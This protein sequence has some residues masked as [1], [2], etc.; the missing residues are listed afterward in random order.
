MLVESMNGRCRLRNMPA[1]HALQEELVRIGLSVPS[2]FRVFYPRVRDREDI[3]VLRCEK[4]GVLL[5]S[6]I[7]HVNLGHY[8]EKVFNGL[9]AQDRA[10]ALRGTKED[11]V[12]R[13]RQFTSIIANKKWLDVGTGAG[14]VLN[15]LASVARDVVAVEPQRRSRESLE[16]AGYRVY[17]NLDE[18]PDQDFDVITLFHVFEHVVNPIEMLAAVKRRLAPGGLLVIEVPHADDILISLFANEAF[19]AHTFW[20]EH[21][22]LHTRE[23]LTAFLRA[24]GFSSVIIQG[25]QRYP[26]ANHLRWLVDGRPGG[27][28]AWSYLRSELLDQAYADMLVRIGKSNTL[29]SFSRV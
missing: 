5:L 26:L 13:A 18:V 15:E 4:S 10:S 7:D 23:S 16:A 11:A 6:R 22:L 17:V 1:M 19:K 12:R 24:A 3:C 20:S 9:G 27:H 8:E 21:L 28:Q 29:I 25:Y 2:S 14:G